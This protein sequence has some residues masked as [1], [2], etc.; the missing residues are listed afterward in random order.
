MIILCLLTQSAIGQ[1]FQNL[2]F[3][4]SCDTSKTGLCRWELSWGAIGSCTPETEGMNQQLLILGKSEN[5]VGFV[6]QSL[7]LPTL[8]EIQL[9]KLSA[10][11]NAENILGK[12]AGLNIGMYD[13]DGN[14]LSTMDMGGFYSVSWIKGTSNWKEYSISAICPE[15]TARIKIGAIL[16]GSGKARFD[17]FRISFSSVNNREPGKIAHNY[18]TEAIDIISTNSLVRDSIDI[19][20]LKATALKI[21]GPAT[22]QSDC[23]LAVRYLLG[24]LRVYGDHHSFFMTPEE[25]VNWE[26]NDEPGKNIS[27]PEF[28]N[29]NSCGYILVPAFHGG[30]EDLMKAYADSLQSGIQTL[31]NESIKGWIIDL[32]KNTGGNMEPMIT[33]LGP[34]FNS[35]KLGSLVDVNSDSESWYYKKG[36]YFWDNEQGISVSN[37]SKIILDLPQAILTSSQTGSSGE[38]VVISFKGNPNTK[39]FGQ[40]TWGLTTGNG[41]FDLPDGARMML[42]STIMADRN[43]V[44]YTGPIV[45]DVEIGVNDKGED[46]TLGAAIE[47]IL[48][49]GR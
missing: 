44:Q 11:I 48:E 41:A 15:G 26:N 39:F 18:I 8:Q 12:G 7:A 40:P 38:I 30:N 3:E 20:Q 34:L 27:Y 16:Y 46:Y 32:R 42:A 24:S 33:G 29:I 19:Y 6:E 9:I 36:S 13:P 43:G 47:W 28:D 35:E 4:Q 45:P 37:H 22:I 5:S 23:H 21:A 2:N 17:N 10:E 49:N 31:N 14:L 1:T 25:V